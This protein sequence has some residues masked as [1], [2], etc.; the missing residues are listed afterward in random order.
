M[1]TTVT[2]HLHMSLPFRLPVPPTAMCKWT[3]MD[4]C[5]HAMAHMHMHAHI[6]VCGG[7]VVDV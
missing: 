7:H 2:E 1:E 6:Y 5:T 4:V 3:I